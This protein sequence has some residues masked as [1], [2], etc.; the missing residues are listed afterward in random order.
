VGKAVIRI[1]A[2][3]GGEAIFVH[4]GELAEGPAHANVGGNGR[5]STGPNIA[6]GRNEPRPGE[7]LC[8]AQVSPPSRGDTTSL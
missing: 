8:A 3:R 1:G 5:K 2:V 7:R 6:T 4:G